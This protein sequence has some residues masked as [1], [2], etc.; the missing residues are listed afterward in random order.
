M[1]CMT[2]SRVAPINMRDDQLTLAVDSIEIVGSFYN[3]GERAQSTGS[4]WHEEN[5]V[6]AIN[7]RPWA[8]LGEKRHMLIRSPGA[9]E[10]PLFSGSLRMVNGRE[11]SSRDVHRLQTHEATVQSIQ[12]HVN[13]KPQAN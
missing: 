9:T 1:V 11:M 3:Y 2:L 5:R 8:S 12:H 10:R 4:N 7:G 13:Y 6:C